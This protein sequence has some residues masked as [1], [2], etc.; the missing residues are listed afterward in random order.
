M[1]GGVFDPAGLTVVTFGLT[2]VVWLVGA[3]CF[4]AVCSLPVRC[5]GGCSFE[6]VCVGGG[7]DPDDRGGGGFEVLDGGGGGGGGGFDD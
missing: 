5:F 1:E 6:G 7:R 2:C 3:G 4:V